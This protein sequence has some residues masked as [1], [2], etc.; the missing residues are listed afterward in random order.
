MGGDLQPVGGVHVQLESGTQDP[1]AT[2]TASGFYM[3]CSVVGTDQ[4]RT[5]T[6]SKDGYTAVTR[7]VFGGWDSMVHL[8]LTRR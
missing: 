7:E 3:I 5:I 1:P 8:E 2:T 4:T 6:A